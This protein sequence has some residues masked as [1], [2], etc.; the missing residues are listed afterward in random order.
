MPDRPNNLQGQDR[1]AFRQID[2][3]VEAGLPARRDLSV[4]DI[5]LFVVRAGRSIS[6]SI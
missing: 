6:T 1:A 3:P 4:A 2:R 5:Y